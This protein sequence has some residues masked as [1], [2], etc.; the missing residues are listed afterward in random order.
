[1]TNLKRL[2]RYLKKR[3]RLV[4][5]FVEQASTANV[6]RL[7]VY[8][9]SDRAGC[10]KTRKSTIGMVLMRD[11]HC[12]KVSSHTQ[13][14]ISLSSG[15][16]E[17]YGIVKCAAIGL[18]ARSMLSDFGM[19]AD[20]VVRTDSSSG[21]A[22]GS[23]RTHQTSG[24]R[25]THDEPVDSDGFRVQRRAHSIGAGSAMTNWRLK[26]SRSLRR[27]ASC[28]EMTIK[29]VFS[30]ATWQQD[31]FW[32][33]AQWFFFWS[34][35]CAIEDPGSQLN[36]HHV[37]NSTDRPRYALQKFVIPCSV[38]EKSG[39]QKRLPIAVS[40]SLRKHWSERTGKGY[41]ESTADTVVCW[42]VACR[43]SMLQ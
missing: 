1:M 29:I 7:D 10:L 14:T 28:S 9:D 3:P 36:R 13:S 5:L 21:L 19:C 22:V 16:S 30:S 39:Q 4:K 40:S 24:R 23:R 25:E 20:V 32:R 37:L 31:F 27:I 2:G 35:E 38:D 26:S 8:G 43:S 41:L 6:V 15:E 12:L 33:R 34:A 17:Y 42:P 11:A 18:G